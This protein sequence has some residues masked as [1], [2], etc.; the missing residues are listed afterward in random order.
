M[1]LLSDRAP[2]IITIHGTADTV[3]PYSQAEALH[4]ALKTRNQLVTMEA[5]GHGRFTDP[6][7]QD[8]RSTIFEFL[9]SVK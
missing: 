9:A 7:W 1:E 5:G 8:A 6:Q 3:V 4:N 2:P